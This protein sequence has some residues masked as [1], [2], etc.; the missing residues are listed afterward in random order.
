[1]NYTLRTLCSN[2][3]GGGKSTSWIV[4][5]SVRG[6]FPRLPPQHAR[7]KSQQSETMRFLTV[8]LRL[9]FSC[10]GRTVNHAGKSESFQSFSVF[11]IIPTRKT[12]ITAAGLFLL[13]QIS[14]HIIPWTWLSSFAQS[15]RHNPRGWAGHGGTQCMRKHTWSA[16]SH[17]DTTIPRA[18]SL[19][20]LATGGRS[21]YLQPLEWIGH[22]EKQ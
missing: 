10:C 9:I 1:M 16:H 22:G 3:S 12:L 5:G 4:P 8:L 11:S 21:I 6:L 15:R 14:R 13:S 20:Q 18:A 2:F 19:S 7:T 17:K